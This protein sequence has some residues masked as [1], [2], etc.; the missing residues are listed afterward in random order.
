MIMAHKSETSDA[1]VKQVPLQKN[2]E[3]NSLA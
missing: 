2:Y 3:R 1:I